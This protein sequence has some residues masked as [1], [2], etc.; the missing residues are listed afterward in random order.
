MPLQ[1]IVVCSEDLVVVGTR[2]RGYV[3]MPVGN[4]KETRPP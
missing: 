1:S 4:L 3:G 2:G